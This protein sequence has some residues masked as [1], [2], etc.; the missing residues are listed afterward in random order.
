MRNHWIYN[1]GG[2]TNTKK[3]SIPKMSKA[4]QNKNYY[5]FPKCV[6]II[7]ARER[8]FYQILSS[9]ETWRDMNEK[10]PDK[11]QCKIEYIANVYYI[12]LCIPEYMS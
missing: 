9:K 10:F 8:K 12:H 5:I 3:S 4:G 2:Q 1:S 6:V 11:N 7:P